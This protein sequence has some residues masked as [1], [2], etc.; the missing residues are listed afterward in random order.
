ME[1]LYRVWKEPWRYKRAVSAYVFVLEAALAALFG[2]A[3]VIGGVQRG[4]VKPPVW[5]GNRKISTIDRE[6]E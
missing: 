4:V 3:P 1:G 2:K 5:R 6:D